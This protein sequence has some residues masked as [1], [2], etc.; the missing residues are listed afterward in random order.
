MLDWLRS[1]LGIGL[2][3]RIR[4]GPVGLDELVVMNAGRLRRTGET[5]AAAHALDPLDFGRPLRSLQ[6]DGQEEALRQVYRAV[7][8]QLRAGFALVANRSGHGQFVMMERD[9]P[10]LEGPVPDML[11]IVMVDVAHAPIVSRLI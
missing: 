6:R 8:L 3:G 5:D 7:E 11:A 4:R 9:Q 2:R 1:R 10:L